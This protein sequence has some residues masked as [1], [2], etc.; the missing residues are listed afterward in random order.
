MERHGLEDR[1][2]INRSALLVPIKPFG[3]A[4][5]RLSPTLAPEARITLA[6]SLSRGVLESTPSL[7][8]FV[9]CET[10]EIAEW[11]V[12]SG[13]RC[14]QNG[15]R[16]LNRSLSM[17]VDTLVAEGYIHVVIAHSDLPLIYDLTGFVLDGKLTIVPDRHLKGTNLLSLP[18]P[19]SFKFHFGPSSFNAH[20]KEASRISLPTFVV[21][22]ARI[23][24]DLDLPSDLELVVQYENE[25]W[26]LVSPPEQQTPSSGG[27]CDQLGNLSQG[28]EDGNHN[29]PR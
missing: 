5:S 13:Y 20:L 10:D 7:D 19:T 12:L 1:N 15:T 25:P 16:G 9:V 29:R 22:D 11:A 17:A 8:T 26:K 3:M 23:G 27:E 4:K 24:L 28:S 6:I 14:I 21:R 2:Y 18:I